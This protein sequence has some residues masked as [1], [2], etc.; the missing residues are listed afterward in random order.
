MDITNEYI[1]CAAICNP[2]EK[3]MAGYPLIY[4]GHRHFNVLWQSDKVSRN[5][6]HQG[7]LTN[8]GRFVNRVDALQIALKANQILDLNE[9]HGN[10]LFSEDLY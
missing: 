2:N 4:C 7:F 10:V 8:K 5:P 6:Y 3:D 9:I 1:L